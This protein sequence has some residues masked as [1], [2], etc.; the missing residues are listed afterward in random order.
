LTAGAAQ[1]VTVGS[2]LERVKLE[3]MSVSE[4]LKS[5]QGMNK[6]ALCGVWRELFNEDAPRQVRKELLIRIL[7]YRIQEQA[8]GGLSV[9]TR[10]RLRELA[11]A[12]RRDPKALLPGTRTVKPGTRLLRQWQGKTHQVTVRDTG[13]EYEGKRHASLSEI[14]R[15]ITGTRW[16]GP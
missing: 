11:Q 12:F 3:T 5:L 13:Y 2:G 15:L 1:S 10:R 7:A 6:A 16:S 4:R 8:F 9:A 14:A